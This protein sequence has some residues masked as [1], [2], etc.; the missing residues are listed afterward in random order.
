MSTQAFT[1][2]LEPNTKAVADALAKFLR[3][4]KAVVVAGGNP[5]VEGAKIGEALVADLF[6][7]LQAINALPGETKDDPKAFYRTLALGV[8]EQVEALLS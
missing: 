5:L 4:V 8:D 7:A 3:D 6:P 1:V 2:Q